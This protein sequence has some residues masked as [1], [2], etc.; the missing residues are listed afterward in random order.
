MEHNNVDSSEK[1]PAH[2]RI[3]RQV[4]LRVFVVGVMAVAIGAFAW[5]RTGGDYLLSALLTG[6][7]TAVID[8]R[9][10]DS[11]RHGR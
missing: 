1:P 7:T 6:L 10:S 5:N 2:H 9:V 11:G 3:R 4:P 8:I